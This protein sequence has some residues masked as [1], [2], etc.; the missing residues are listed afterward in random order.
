M[1]NVEKGAE[2]ERWERE[3][4]SDLWG[5]KAEELGAPGGK[6]N[7]NEKGR[8]GGGGGRK[9]NSVGDHILYKFE[10]VL[11]QFHGVDGKI[12]MERR[13]QTW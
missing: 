7:R 8:P 5:P 12:R 3:E 6:K 10:T 9:E 11:M 1:D 2:S 13:E 4:E